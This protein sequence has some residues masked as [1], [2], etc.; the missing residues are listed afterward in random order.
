LEVLQ[1]LFDP[2]GGTT[3]TTKL[4]LKLVASWRH[5]VPLLY[6]ALPTAEALFGIGFGLA[7]S[8]RSLVD[9]QIQVGNNMLKN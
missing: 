8:G 2:P 1:L 7:W 4:L 3:I 5:L 6:R 9:S